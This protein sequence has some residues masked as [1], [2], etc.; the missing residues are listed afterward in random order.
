MKQSV[1]VVPAVVEVATRRGLFDACDVEVDTLMVRSSHEQRAQLDDGTATVAIT[2]SDNLFVWNAD[3][4]D[5]LLIGQIETTTDLSLMMRP[6]VPSLHDARPLRLA[7]DA[8]TNGFAIVAYAMLSASQVIREDYEIVE[9]GGVRERFEALSNGRADTTLLAPPL[10]EVGRVQ[11]MSVAMTIGELT[12]SYPGLGIVSG[13]RTTGEQADEIERYLRALTMAN[14]WMREA[15]PSEVEELLGAAGMGPAAVG[16]AIA[17]APEDLSPHPD[18]LRTLAALR[19]SVGMSVEAAP[20][21][22][23]MLGMCGR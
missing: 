14:I 1:F 20:D 5:I 13:R 6:G 3:G 22:G 15:N 19:E 8:P 17:N 23:A 11:G 16:S 21:V 2:A 7:V 9:I 4:S 12:P 10:D 18:G